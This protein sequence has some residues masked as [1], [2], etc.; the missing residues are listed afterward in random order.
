MIWFAWVYRYK[1]CNRSETNMLNCHS[2]CTDFVYPHFFISFIVFDYNN[3]LQQS[4]V[5][6][7]I[8]LGIC[9]LQ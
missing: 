1:M 7:L 5:Y 8:N 4:Y 9:K 6:F 2:F 3:I